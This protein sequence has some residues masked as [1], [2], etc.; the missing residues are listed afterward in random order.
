MTVTTVERS[1]LFV[2]GSP[3]ALKLH[4]FTKLSSADREA[5]GRLSKRVRTVD[6]R[7]DLISEG[8]PPTHVHLVLQGWASRYKALPDGKRQIVGLF[9]P[10]DFCDLNIY[11][12]KQMDH[13]IGAITRLRVAMITPEEM[14]ELTSSFPRVTQAL[15][16]H[17]LVTSATQREWLLNIGQRTAYQ[18]LAHLFVEL[19]LRLRSVGMT[20]HNSCDFPLTQNDLADATGLTPVH[21]NRMLQDL[22]HDGLIELERKHLRIPD[23]ERLKD[24]AMFNPN[25]L[26]LGHEG[27]YLDSNE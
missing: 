7:R 27:A 1:A 18:R 5:L 25:Y 23:I 8:D 9:V 6:A 17:E 2:S 11:I 12:L 26:H 15:L 20:Q 19:Y 14:D 16:W 3:V 4:A 24:V 13:S 22:R 21:V 10:G